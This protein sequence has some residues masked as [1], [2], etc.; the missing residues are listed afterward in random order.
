MPDCQSIHRRHCIL[1]LKS[2]W[3][4]DN[5]QGYRLRFSNDHPNSLSANQ[6]RELHNQWLVSTILTTLKEIFQYHWRHNCRSNG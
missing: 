3:T 5:M 2:S 6:L 4:V 1:L